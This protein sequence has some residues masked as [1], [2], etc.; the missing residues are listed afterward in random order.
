ML[1]SIVKKIFGSRN[2]RLVK[3]YMQKVRAINA[4]E[5]AMEKLSDVNWP[6]R[7]PSSN[8]AS[9]RASRACFGARCAISMC[10]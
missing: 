10:R 7:R 5:P 3:Q 8:P 1:Q 6:P 9:N 2:D 4:F